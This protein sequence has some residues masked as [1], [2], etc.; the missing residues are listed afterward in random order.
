MTDHDHM[1]ALLAAATPGPWVACD[2][3]VARLRDIVHIDPEGREVTVACGLYPADAALI[4][5]VRAELPR[6]LDEIERLRAGIGG[7]R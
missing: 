7:S 3:W 1:R 2:N 5:A 6:L 4:V